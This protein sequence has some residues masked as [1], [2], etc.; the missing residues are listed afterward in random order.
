MSQVKLMSLI[1]KTG[2]VAVI[3]RFSKIHDKTQVSSYGKFF[4]ILFI[5]LLYSIF[6]LLIF[7]LLLVLLLQAFFQRWWR[8]QSEIVQDVVRK[9]VSSGQ[10][11]FMYN[12]CFLCPYLE[13]TSLLLILS[14]TFSV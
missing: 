13:L 3:G 12:Y 2:K 11:E 1:I 5:F 9:L 8:D 10:L 7:T 14:T 4:K 6:C